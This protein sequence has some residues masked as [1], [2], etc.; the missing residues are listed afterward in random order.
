M[1]YDGPQIFRAPYGNR[2]A[3]KNFERTL[4]E[5]VPIDRFEEH[6]DREFD[7]E[8]DRADICR[9]RRGTAT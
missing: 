3:L 9:R 7:V 6:T 2:A 5:G 1:P 8:T 4:I